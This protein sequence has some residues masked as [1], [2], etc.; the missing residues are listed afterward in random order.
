MTSLRTKGACNPRVVARTCDFGVIAN[1]LRLG[2]PQ[3]RGRRSLQKAISVPQ[4][5]RSSRRAAGVSRL[6]WTVCALAIPL[7][8]AKPA[9]ADDW[10][11]WRGP[12]RDGV[13]RETGVVEKF[14]GPEV[15]ILWRT[16]IGSGYSGPTVYEG[17]VYVTDRIVEP[18]QQERVHCFDARDGRTLWSFTYDCPYARVGYEAGPRASVSCH[19]GKAYAL[20]TMGHLHCFDAA[21]GK[22][23]WKHDLDTE[24]KIEMPIWGIAASPLVEGDLLIVQVG[25]EKACLA[26]FDKTTGAERWTAL[27]DD[28]ASYAAP[29][30]VEQAGRRVLVCMT[31][32]NVHGLDPQTG[33]VYWTE[34][35]PP[36]NMPIGISTPVVSGNRVFCTSFY[37][38][39]L[40]IELDPQATTAK[41]LWRR[42]GASEK[43]TD[44]LH[45][46]IATPLFLGD[47]VYGV[48]SYG[49]LRCLDAKTGDR[50]WEDKTAVPP[51]RWSNIHL[52]VNG[53]LVWMFNERGELLITKL[54]PQGFT[55]ISRAKLIEPT[56]DQLRQRGGVCWSHPAYAGR[57][58]F[59]RNDKELVCGDLERR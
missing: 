45:S 56:T 9:G 43:K 55:E 10:P 19:E 57:H 5:A 36:Q 21:T 17:R 49:E 40:M 23:L 15:P 58:V 59:A 25:G 53:E 38:G 51:A 2:N 44:A 30:I 22:V 16:P 47:Y 41:T 48:D 39:S 33:K 35:F 29:I 26:A 13:W 12:E 54:S 27:D 6:L 46:I 24:Y 1:P 20:G 37:D 11:Q 32:D 28:R 31:G 8:F 14:A 7:L 18:A 4:I 50:L 3:R 42:K 34:P 52:T